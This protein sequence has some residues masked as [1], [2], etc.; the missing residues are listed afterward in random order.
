MIT[1]ILNDIFEDYAEEC[2][3]LPSKHAQTYPALV[4]LQSR[5]SGALNP[6]NN[7][8]AFMDKKAMPG[9]A[10]WE[11]GL[12]MACDAPQDM[13]T[14]T[15]LTIFDSTGCKLICDAAQPVHELDPETR[16]KTVVAWRMALRGRQRGIRGV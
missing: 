12:I 9:G 6:R 7:L 14:T 15:E 8:F 10:D 2:T 4:V 5:S 13:Q 16:R 11:Y 1:E 3:V